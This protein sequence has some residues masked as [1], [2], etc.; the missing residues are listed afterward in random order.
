[1]AKYDVIKNRLNVFAS[2]NNI[3]NE[4]FV[5]TVGYSTRGRNFKIG[6][7]VLF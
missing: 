2:V 1:M 7:N 4:K 5:E 3:L 6:V